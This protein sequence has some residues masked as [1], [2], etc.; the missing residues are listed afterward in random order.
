MYTDRFDSEIIPFRQ[1]SEKS[2]QYIKYRN[3][4]YF[5]IPASCDVPNRPKFRPTSDISYNHRRVANSFYEG[6]LLQVI[7]IGKMSN[8]I[9]ES[10]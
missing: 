1:T 6:F 5:E 7:H 9:N 3:T 10:Y 4:N 8:K 2:A